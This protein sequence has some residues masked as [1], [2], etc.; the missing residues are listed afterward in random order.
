MYECTIY[1]RQYVNAC[2]CVN[3]KTNV[4]RDAYNLFSLEFILHEMQ[5]IA[6][7]HIIFFTSQIK[8]SV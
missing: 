4:F 3:W 7:H 6:S 2:I 8:Y 5:F 1:I